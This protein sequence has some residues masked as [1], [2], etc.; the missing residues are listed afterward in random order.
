MRDRHLPRLCRSCQGP[1]ARQADTCWRCGAR[2]VDEG[3]PRT[4]LR[5]VPGGAGTQPSVEP[6]PAISVAAP[7]SV[8]AATEARVAAGAP[9]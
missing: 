4:T 7:A 9:R 6:A 1:M 3:A 2:W 5:V 8:R